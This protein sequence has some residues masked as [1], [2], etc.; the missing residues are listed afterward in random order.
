MFK[1]DQP[2]AP[3]L[4]ITVGNAHRPINWITF[5]IGACDAL[6]AVTESKVAVNGDAEISDCDFRYTFEV[7]EEVR[8]ILAI[9]VSTEILFSRHDVENNETIVRYV[10]LHDRI[11]IPGVEGNCELVLEHSDCC[12]ITLLFHNCPFPHT[13]QNCALPWFLRNPQCDL[14]IFIL[15][16]RIPV[17]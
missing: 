12:F 17:L 10:V 5:Q 7:R 3:Y 13:C 16:V 4:T 9:C 14:I 8:P 2:L 6:E 1:H 15:P 11:N